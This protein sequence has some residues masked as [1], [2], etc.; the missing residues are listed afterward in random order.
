MP[1]NRATAAECRPI[2]AATVALIQG[3]RC[4]GH[5]HLR[6]APTFGMPYFGPDTC[7]TALQHIRM[8][9][10]TSLCKV[11]LLL[12]TF[13]DEIEVCTVSTAY[14]QTGG[15]LTVLTASCMTLCL[16]TPSCCV[17]YVSTSDGVYV[18]A[19]ALHAPGCPS[20]FISSAR[21]GMLRSSRSSSNGL[22]ASRPLP[23]PAPQR[24]SLRSTAPG[25]RLACDLR[26]GS[27]RAA[28]RQPATQTGM[29]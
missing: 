1:G 7:N 29:L 16:S 27:R 15:L 3:T 22:G 13:N 18:S 8:E 12:H 19:H 4:L 9:S 14:L 28:N 23:S 11:A 26:C 5:Q 17:K 20:W 6:P 24:A 25:R 21:A 2:P 10:E